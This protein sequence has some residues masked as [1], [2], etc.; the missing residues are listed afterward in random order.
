MTDLY[1]FAYPSGFGQTSSGRP[2]F[3]FYSLLIIIGFAMAYF[4]S[5]YRAHKDGFDW[6][7]F[8]T[9]FVIGLLFFAILGA[10]IWYVIANFESSYAYMF[11]ESFWTGFVGII[12]ISQGGLAI[13]GGII[14]ATLYGIVTCLLT[15]RNY[16][17]LRIIDYIIPTIF[18]GQFFGRW[19]NFFNQEVLGHAVLPEAWGFLPKFITNNMQNGGQR[20]LSGIRL[21]ENS[22]AA[23][24]FIVEGVLNM[25]AF[26][27][28]A[29]ALPRV[30][31]KYYKPGDSSFAYFFAY[32][33]IRVILEPV[34]HSS[35]IMGDS[36]SALPTSVIMSLVF[37]SL[38]LGLIIANHIVS[39]FYDTDKLCLKKEA[40]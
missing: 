13:Q 33:L 26:V 11:E 32:G 23:P 22:I 7:F 6:S 30:L 36:D 31:G 39:K 10:R 40:N 8:S 15:R 38:G 17:I 34:R 1:F 5:N 21:P 16:S 25:L 12:N 2:V 9:G 28:V 37:I 18:I 3:A 35:F 4:I 27:I 14:F 29:I 20:L 24:L 19:G